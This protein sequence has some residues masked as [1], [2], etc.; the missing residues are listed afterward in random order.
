METD[1]EVDSGWAVLGS[2]ARGVVGSVL[3]RGLDAAVPEPTGADIDERPA[4]A[5]AS[6]LVVSKSLTKKVD[7]LVVADPYT[8]SGKA[9]KAREYGTRVMAEAVFWQ[10][11]GIQVE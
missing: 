11:L 10:S 6:G 2:E 7:V 5:E 1:I 9:K 8:Q 3:A 4:K